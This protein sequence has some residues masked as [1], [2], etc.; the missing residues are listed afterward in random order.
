MNFYSIIQLL[1]NS[2]IE[3]NLKSLSEVTEIIKC[4]LS[5]D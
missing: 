4:P 3:V 5:L 1:N 2:Q